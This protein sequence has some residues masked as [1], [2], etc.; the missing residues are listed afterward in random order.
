[1]GKGISPLVATVLLIAVTMTIAGVLA[2]WASGFVA[3]SLPTSSCAVARFTIQSKSYD[4][5][6][7]KMVLFIQNNGP[8]DL[9]ITNITF[10]YADGTI[11]TRNIS[12]RLPSASLKSVV[13]E[14][15]T[16]NYILCS[17]YS[18]CPNVY[19]SCA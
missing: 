16:S 10:G 6:D 13:L 3:S 7:Q 12:E 15:V 1:M 19:A 2:Y 17:I 4:I 14:N 18:D 5:L 8:V 9:V 11:D